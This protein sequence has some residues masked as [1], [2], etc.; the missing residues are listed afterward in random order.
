MTDYT[1]LEEMECH[2]QDGL[3]NGDNAFHTARRIM[4]ALTDE[5]VRF[6]RGLKL[7]DCEAVVS[8]QWNW[9]DLPKWPGYPE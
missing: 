7:V 4:Q 9:A 1:I 3:D 8:D 2:I 6:G 5:K